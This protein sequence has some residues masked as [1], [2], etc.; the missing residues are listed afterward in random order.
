MRRFVWFGVALVLLLIC[1]L[2]VYA[3]DDSAVRAPHL[4]L[5]MAISQIEIGETTSLMLLGASLFGLAA[6]TRRLK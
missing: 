3:G 2:S 4:T 6:G 5:A 1:S